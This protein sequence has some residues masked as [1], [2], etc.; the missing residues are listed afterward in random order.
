MQPR[1]VLKTRSASIEVT[2]PVSG[3]TFWL[4]AYLRGGKFVLQRLGPQLFPGKETPARLV[5]MARFGEAAMAAY[6]EK[7]VGR[8]P[9]A[10]LRVAA[11]RGTREGMKKSESARRGAPRPRVSNQ[12]FYRN[13][14]GVEKVEQVENYLRSIVK[15]RARY[16]KPRRV[17]APASPES[18]PRP[19]EPNYREPSRAPIGPA[20]TSS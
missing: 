19:R 18:S 8:L 1:I 20:R 7:M 17:L 16:A 5:A 9:P 13:L 4:T 11:L 14:V 2:D 3:V 15:L 10:A 6:R 12:E